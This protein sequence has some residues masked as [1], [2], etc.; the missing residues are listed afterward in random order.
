MA[1]ATD[2]FST[3]KFPVCAAT[4]DQGLRWLFDLATVL[5]LL[6]CRPGDCVLDLGAGSGFS[7]EMLAR[8]GYRVVAIDPDLH[9]LDNNRARPLFD[10]FRIDGSVRVAGA[11][12]E[13]LPFL[14]ATFDGV[15]ALNVLHHV[16]DLASVTAELARVMK[17][18]C[19]AVFCE[20]GLD[21]LH[22]GETQRAM[23][24]HGETDRPFDAIEFLN[25]AR[26]RGFKDGMLCATL[27][28]PLR[29]LPVQE[30]DLFLSGLH[31]RPHMTPRG[32]IDELQRRHAYGMLVRDGQ[33]P[34]TSR[35]PGHLHASIT[36]REFP[37]DLVR[38]ETHAALVELANI[39]DSVWLSEPNE[40]GGF[41]TVGCKLLHPDGR[42]IDDTIGRTI[43]PRDVLPGEHIQVRM[44]IAIPDR[45]GA[46][47][48]VL[49]VDAINELIAWFA[50]LSGNHPQE[51][52]VSIR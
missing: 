6:D 16:P 9:A 11:V 25:A 14:D 40:F 34:R 28:S 38:G 35:Y 10:R 33:R 45:I 21:H 26:Q 2:P 50:D 39:G 4:H 31:P 27:Q 5:L 8:C 47:A 29:L 20:P 51:F 3:G 22:A 13:A 48:Y 32:V 49:R 43:L 44:S 18:G 17:P 15:L 41:V 37:R 24:E 42:L 30:I 19:R 7:S 46:G 1:S 12:A 52:R 36:V 23:R